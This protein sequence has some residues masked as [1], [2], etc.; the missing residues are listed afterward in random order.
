MGPAPSAASIATACLST[1]WS[2]DGWN[3]LNCV[4]EQLHRPE[5]N[6]ALAVSICV[7]LT[8]LCYML[9][10]AGLFGVFTNQQVVAS[11]AIAFQVRRHRRFLFATIAT[12][13]VVVDLCPNDSCLI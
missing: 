10:N 1:L 11:D 12:V 13:V 6:L 3:S 2:Y 9:F 5:R 4:V 8:T 7:P